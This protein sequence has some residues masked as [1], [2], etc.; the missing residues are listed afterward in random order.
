[1]RASKKRKDER[2]QLGEANKNRKKELRKKCK[3]ARHIMHKYKYSILLKEDFLDAF[4]SRFGYN[5]IYINPTS[6]E[7]S[8]FHPFAR[9][10][11]NS[12]T[13]DLYMSLAKDEESELI[14]KDI[15]N[16]IMW[17]VENFPTVHKPMEAMEQ[18]F[19][20]MVFVQR[21]V[22]TKHVLMSESYIW[23][24]IDGLDL[25]LVK[26]AMSK[27]KSKNPRLS[28]YPVGISD[29]SIQGEEAF[30]DEKV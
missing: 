6:K 16:F 1:M 23:D 20:K 29:F 30:Q 19:D 13:G 3:E 2:K 24:D 15:V 4:N 7:W 18:I 25:G 11:I 8:S 22:N 27:C 5:E 14:H 10:V 9:G 21:Y 12:Q 17:K 28:F 26:E